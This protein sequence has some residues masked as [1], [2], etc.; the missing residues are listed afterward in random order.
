MLPLCP[1]ELNAKTNDVADKNL[2][3]NGQESK[4]EHAHEAGFGE[5]ACSQCV[6]VSNVVHAKQQCRH[7]CDDDHAHDAF[8]V[9]GVMDVRS[10]LR[11]G[12][13]HEEE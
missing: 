10:A 9:D 4:D 13:G 2:G 11:G 1:C 8:G 12:L 3:K 6:L 7:Q 5:L